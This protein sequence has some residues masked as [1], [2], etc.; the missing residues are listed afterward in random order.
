M[1][2]FTTKPERNRNPLSE[3]ISRP[4]RAAIPA[5]SRLRPVEPDAYDDRTDFI[6]GRR[7]LSQ[8]RSAAPDA[9]AR[10]YEAICFDLELGDAGAACSNLSRLAGHEKVHVIRAVLRDCSKDLQALPEEFRPAFQKELNSV[11]KRVLMRSAERFE[12]L[13][14]RSP[15]W[16][17]PG[18]ATLCLQL[19]GA[20]PVPMVR[21]ILKLMGWSE[22]E[23]AQAVERRVQSWSPEIECD[24]ASVEWLWTLRSGPPVEERRQL[25]MTVC[26]DEPVDL[27]NKARGRVVVGCF[28]LS[29]QFITD[30]LAGDL[31]MKNFASLRAIEDHVQF[32]RT[33][34]HS[35]IVDFAKKSRANSIESDK[36]FGALLARQAGLLEMDQAPIC[37]LMVRSSAHAMGVL[38]RRYE[39]EDLVQ[40]TCTVTF[41]DPYRTN[42]LVELSAGVAELASTDLRTYLDGFKTGVGH[43]F[44]T[45]F[46][47]GN[48]FLVNMFRPEDLSGVLPVAPQ[49]LGLVADVPISP[50]LLVHLLENNYAE[51]LEALRPQLLE[52]SGDELAA[53]LCSGIGD[54]SS[55]LEAAMNYGAVAAF[56]A[57][58]P[59][60]L[61]KLTPEQLHAV[62][63]RNA[64]GLGSAYMNG[65]AEIID[66]FLDMAAVLSPDQRHEIHKKCERLYQPDY[67][68][69]RGIRTY[70]DRFG[71][72]KFEPFR[73][74]PPE[75]EHK[76]K[77]VLS[78]YG[79]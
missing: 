3:P 20:A 24:G 44:D 67:F 35:E 18:L 64:L 22:A 72:R 41:F 79:Y 43:T 15:E 1:R 32:G 4:Q 53:Q 14:K 59:V 77:Q 33:G 66:C 34:K 17:R 42:C 48:C 2:C 13:I 47:T 30:A 5:R 62:L 56:Q 51:A 36:S 52:L 45:L 16:A 10:A 50:A 70:R 31:D 7:R 58:A 71:E 69:T 19:P 25:Q 21:H 37:A 6:R 11:G 49:P 46:S 68:K 57:L 40:S 28:Q 73:D 9:L 39:G 54:L 23:I 63:L 76:H 61:E 78:M 12:R 26:G 60:L 8:E 74:L 55:P 65:W 38:L 27:N 75:L 29:A